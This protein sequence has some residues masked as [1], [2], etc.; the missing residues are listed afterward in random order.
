MDE[1]YIKIFG[2]GLILIGGWFIRHSL[3]TRDR[4]EEAKRWPSVQGEV[5]ESEVKRHAH[6]RRKSVTYEARIRYR[7]E[8]NGTPYTG[9]AIV[10]G[11]EVRSS[12]VKAAARCEK[13]HVGATPAVFYDPS[14]PETACLER[15]H[16]G[17]WLELVGGAFG[18]AIGLLL[19][20]GVLP[21]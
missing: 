7:Y 1:I 17:L 11:G 16:E 14:N 19:L 18:I 4:V 13:Y 12:R 8:V 9:K 3:R 15:V 21:R 2:A 6:R 20:L 10:I 5:V